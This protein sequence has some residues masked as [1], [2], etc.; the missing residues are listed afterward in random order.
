MAQAMGIPVP[1]V[2]TGGLRDR[3]GD[4]GGERRALRPVRRR[5]P[6]D[7]LRLHA[8]RVHRGRGRRHGEPRRLDPRLDLREPARVLRRDRGEPGPGR[9]RLV[10]RAG[11]D[12]CSS[13]PPASSSR[14][15]NDRDDRGAAE[16]ARRRLLDRVRGGGG[17]AG[18]RADRAAAVLAALRHRDPDLGA[19]GDVLGHPD[20]LHRHGLVRPLGVLRPRHVRRRRRAPHRQAAEP[21]AGGALRPGRRRRRR[22]VRRLLRDAAARH[23]LLDHDPRVLADLL[24]HHLHL[25]RGDRRRERAHLPPARAV[26]PGPLERP[27]HAPRPSTGSCWRW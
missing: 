16:I 13:G 12:A 25:D 22:R 20:R 19:P 21:L 11:P 7:G 6:D 18:D 5:H 26:D 2:Y 23:L 24:R 3:L 10:R 8:A 27:L 14:R 15:R 17:A 9:D 4:G 1:L